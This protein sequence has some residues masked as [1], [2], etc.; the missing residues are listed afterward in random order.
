MNES[1]SATPSST[2]TTPST[3]LPL[4]IA[5][6]LAIL[7][8][9][10]LM[11][12]S[13][14]WA[15]VPAAIAGILF[16]M[17]AALVAIEHRAARSHSLPAS[18]PAAD[19]RRTVRTAEE[20]T[21]RRTAITIIIGL[22][23]IAIVLSSIV[24]DWRFIAIGALGIFAWMSLLGLP[25]WVAAVEDEAERKHEALTGESRINE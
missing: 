21:G 9:I 6:L 14:S 18:M 2:T 11:V 13:W 10:G 16:C 24:F 4:R 20:G 7:I 22:S 25:F 12:S 3:R 8:T 19:R 17:D 15:W 5:L 1:S 23:A